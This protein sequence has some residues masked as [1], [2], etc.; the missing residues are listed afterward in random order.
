VK[1]VDA[2]RTRLWLDH[3]LW[4]AGKTPHEFGRAYVERDADRF[5]DSK[6]V[7]KWAAL[8]RK[9]SL[10]RVL[11][12]DDAVPGTAWVYDL[13]LFDL[14]APSPLTVAKIERLTMSLRAGESL[15]HDWHFPGEQPFAR[16]HTRWDT[17]GLVERGDI[18]ALI[19]TLACVRHAE[20][21]HDTDAL[22]KSLQD[23][24]RILPGVLKTPWIRRALPQFRACLDLI[25]IRAP[26]VACCFLVNW[27]RI[28]IYRDWDGYEPLRHLRERDPETRRFIEYSDVVQS[29][30]TP[31][32][33]G[34]PFSMIKALEAQLQA[35]EARTSRDAREATDKRPVAQ[36]S[37]D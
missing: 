27:K 13:P 18:W 37:F 9:P 6:V 34:L 28:E 22:A 25:R 21:I 29:L 33:P 15:D 32:L 11:R 1:A 36:L 7:F 31:L 12:I 30:P 8:K 26:S 2:L 17:T 3:A 4:K 35:E 14:L 5:Q 16:A 10:E 20:A 24:F 19:A 23:V